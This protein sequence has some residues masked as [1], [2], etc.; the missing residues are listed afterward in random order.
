M[1]KKDN[2]DIVKLVL[3]CDL[4]ASLI[5]VLAQIYPDA[6]P[7]VITMS[8]EVADVEKES[9]VGLDVDPLTS[10]AA[11][12]GIG[13]EYYALGSLAK[14]KFAGTSA[15]RDLK[16]Q[17]AVPK[18]AGL[19]W[20]VCHHLALKETEVFIHL[21]L[22][23]GEYKDGN[24]LGKQLS[25]VLKGGIA[26][27]TG[28]LKLKVRNFMVSLEGCGVLASRRRTL[29]EA[30]SKRTI[31]MLML[32]YRNASFIVVKGK[33]QIKA[34]STDLGMNWLV[35]RFV[36]HASVGLCKDDLHIPSALV[37]ANLGNFEALRS[38]SRKTKSADIESDLALFQ[39]SLTLVR[40]EYCRA[41]LRWIRNIASVDEVLLC[42]GT[43]EFVR[44]ELTQFFEEESIPI[45]WNGGV[46]IPAALDT[47]KLGNRLADV[48][49]LHISHINMLDMNF[50]YDRQ[51]PLVPQA[52]KPVNTVQ[53]CHP[54]RWKN[55]LPM[56][57]DSPSSSLP[58]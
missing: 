39:K 8:P 13:S 17:Y 29:G 46:D 50:Q 19:L 51:Q 6:T 35:E 49:A 32:G 58:S 11:W 56:L 18:L 28:R 44:P 48:W 15:I 52:A 4:G 2:S 25:A 47:H 55:F 38:L 42:G 23:S 22:P 12:V 20:L 3:T 33:N 37:K 26:T 27:P 45:V 1:V 36:E 10:D 30:Y 34:E 24:N 5:K 41:L 57:V 16:Y 7:Q 43:G 40:R 9:V 14:N 54:D 31:G 53:R 21:L